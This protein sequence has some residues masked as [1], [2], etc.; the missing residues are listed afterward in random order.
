MEINFNPTIM[1]RTKIYEGNI[2]EGTFT[3][4]STEIPQKI[5]KE[6]RIL[7][8]KS[9]SGALISIE[10]HPVRISFKTE[11]S[12]DVGHLLPVGTILRLHSSDQ[13]ASLTFKSVQGLTSG[14]LQITLEFD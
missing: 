1:Q 3:L 11:V 4:K 7:D 9:A 6:K 12:S 13:I 8:N 14:T 10:D 5:P 2:L